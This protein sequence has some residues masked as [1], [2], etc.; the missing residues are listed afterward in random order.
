[1]PKPRRE[2]NAQAAGEWLSQRILDAL[3][4]A[5]TNA[6]RLFSS[7]QGWVE[8]LG[9]D[10]LLS[11]QDEAVRD[12]MLDGLLRWER[13]HHLTFERI[14][15]RFLPQRNEER[16]APKLIRGDPS[17]PL[18]SVVSENGVAFGIDFSGGYSA[19]LFIDQRANR[20]HLRNARAATVLNTFAYTCS[21]SVVAALGGSVTTS[22][23]LSRKSLTRGEENFAR[24]RLDPSTHRFIH[25]DVLDLLPRLARRG[26]RFDAIILDPPTFSRGEKGRRFQVESDFEDLLITALELAEPRAHILLSTNCTRL[27]ASS[28]EQ[29]ARFALKA[30]RRSATF[31]RE[32]PLPDIPEAFAA[33]TLWMVMTS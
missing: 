12:A 30:T 15:A 11:Y 21:F 7:R 31:H 19:G 28:L 3:T 25:A 26:E 2:P 16:A 9:N 22:V 8:R 32:P 13:E 18:E 1:M 23:D 14:F 24:N 10:A 4:A 17:L 33:Q 20:A 5:E 6:H 27:R 29:I